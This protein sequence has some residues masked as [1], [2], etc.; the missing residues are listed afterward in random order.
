MPSRPSTS[1][2]PPTGNRAQSPTPSPR[3]RPRQSPEAHRDR[4][5][6]LA[7]A[8]LGRA[9]ARTASPSIAEQQQQQRWRGGDDVDD[10]SS[11]SSGSS[12]WRGVLDILSDLQR[13]ADGGDTSAPSPSRP[14]PLRSPHPEDLQDPVVRRA[15]EVAAEAAA[16]KRGSA[17]GN[18]KS[19]NDTSYTSA[20]TDGGGSSTGLSPP[21]PRRFSRVADGSVGY[22]VALAQ[23]ATGGDGDGGRG[24]GG[25][26]SKSSQQQ[27]ESRSPCCSRRAA[28]LALIVLFALGAVG[29][30]VGFLLFSREDGASTT[31]SSGSAAAAGAGAADNNDN[32]NANGFAN[33]DDD[34]N[35]DSLGPTSSDAVADEVADN[36]TTKFPP[37]PPM[38]SPTRTPTSTSLPKITP[39]SSPSTETY[40]TFSFVVLGD[41]PYSN[42]EAAYLEAQLYQLGIDADGNP[43][44]D[45][46]FAVHVG[47]IMQGSE[48]RKNPC[49][50]DEYRLVEE[51][52]TKV[53]PIPIFLQPGDNDWMECQDAEEGWGHWQSSFIDLDKSWAAH[54]NLAYSAGT[55]GGLSSSQLARVDVP[56]VMSPHE[57]TGLVQRQAKRKENFAFMH[58]HVLF[59]GVNMIFDVYS[60]DER[61]L[62]MED[63]KEFVREQLG[64]RSD[65]KLR[66]VILFGHAWYAD[67]FNDMKEE[68]TLGLGGVPVVYF[69]GNGHEWYFDDRYYGN[70]NPFYVMQ[71][72]NGAVAPPL[73]ITVYGDDRPYLNE[74]DRKGANDNLIDGFIGID[75]QGGT[76]QGHHLYVGAGAPFLIALGAEI[77][78][79]KFPPCGMCEGDC[80]SDDDCADG[81]VCIQR[82]EFE[83]VTGCDDPIVNMEGW[84]FCARG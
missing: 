84:D 70:D 19:L 48:S 66:A 28:L 80:D 42:I 3:P 65:L 36:P 50:R 55:S 11:A 52:M 7:A 76:D 46:L 68:L 20:E 34:F 14:P 45:D 6:A 57:F 53:S 81:L 4:L 61:E 5:N 58:E 31:S 72:D 73:K 10:N 15:A 24:G 71:V 35:G 79:G 56:T 62:R 9:S 59:I 8:E 49:D 37:K 17:N 69:H 25:G 30:G 41:I 67:F 23:K 83:P 60:I 54:Q 32:A 26:K 27:R 82:D 13:Q 2:S 51:I 47:D 38:K 63:N 21:S 39:A 64:L 44:I 29:A 77:C 12:H 1:E 18:S 22:E 43:N 40:K 75:R 78:G 74:E 16:C 33:A